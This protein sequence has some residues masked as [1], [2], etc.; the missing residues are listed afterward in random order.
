M[1][2][3]KIFSLLA[4]IFFVA[5]CANKNVTETTQASEIPQAVANT[6]DA[7]AVADS[8]CECMEN[9]M[10]DIAEKDATT[11]ASLQKRCEKQGLVA[12]GNF[13]SD[14]TKVAAVNAM[15][16]QNC[17]HLAAANTLPLQSQVQSAKGQS[18][19]QKAKAQM[20]DF[21]NQAANKPE[22]KRSKKTGTKPKLEMEIE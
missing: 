14:A 4:M 19:Q 7:A 1:N 16:E 10:K 9:A 15:I 11:M 20:S 13:K 8:M 22:P 21:K 6:F 17:S 3:N 12:F 2:F 5:S 18:A